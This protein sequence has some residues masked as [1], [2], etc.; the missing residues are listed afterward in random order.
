[1]AIKFKLVQRKDL[2]KGTADDAKRFYASANVTGKM[3]FQAIC[4]RIAD[5]STASDGDV[6]LVLRGLI[7][8]MKEAL[9]R[10]E[11]VQLGDL[12]HFQAVIGSKGSLTEEEF[13]VSLI[14]KPRII[15]RPGADLRDVVRKISFER[16]VPD[17]ITKECDR[18]H[19][20]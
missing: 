20:V 15:F 19:T 8:C 6:A 2:T 1:M 7:H 13:N 18:P 14:K 5:R 12:G 9:L 11:S 4:A 3:D 17:V 10:G 16:I